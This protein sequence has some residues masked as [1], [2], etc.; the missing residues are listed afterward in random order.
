METIAFWAAT[1][2][3]ALATVGYFVWAAFR[4]DRAG[5]AG[6]WL[7]AAGTIPHAAAVVLRWIAVGHG[8]YNTRYEVLS[9]NVLVL[10]VVLLVASARAKELGGLGAFVAP[11]AFLG[12]GWA[13]SS[14]GVRAEVPIIL[15]SSWLVLHVG[16]AKL[17]AATALLAAACAAAFLVK[18]R[19]TE[20]LRWLPSAARLDLHAHQFLLVSFL[21]LGVMIV[22]GSLW[23]HQSWGRY[24]GWDPIETSSLV[25]WIVFGIILHFRVLHGWSGRRMAL[26][27][28][29]GLAFAL[30]TVYVVAI[31]VPTIH[32][33]YLVG[34]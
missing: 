10:V 6:R 16:F 31:V 11:L 32:D 30:T 22:A 27:T 20:A 23:A 28:F 1:A 7:L 15:R 9:A 4:A 3:Y 12:M 24:W 2:C 5:T 8:P 17:F 13:V 25:T 21:F 29:V 19:R 33:A 26:L 14:F 18:A 34:G